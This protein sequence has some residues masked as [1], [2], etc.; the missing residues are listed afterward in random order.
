MVGRFLQISPRARG[1]HLLSMMNASLWQL[2][3]L[4]AH[5]EAEVLGA[6]QDYLA[7]MRP[8]ELA[9]LP[10]PLTPALLADPSDV[11]DYVAALLRHEGPGERRPPAREA[12]TAFLMT[13]ARRLT[14]LQ[15][16]TAAPEGHPQEPARTGF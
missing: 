12:L 10:E 8:D 7:L 9:A 6:V 2:E 16:Q 5:D 4:R 1:D 13:A 3:V 15:S 14:E 11:S